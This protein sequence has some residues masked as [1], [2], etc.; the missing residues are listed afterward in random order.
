[1]HPRLGTPGSLG[2]REL[3]GRGLHGLGRLWR[4][5]DP[6]TGPCPL[7]PALRSGRT[8]RHP[9]L[10]DCVMHADCFPRGAGLVLAAQKEGHGLE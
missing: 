10:G 4:R 6:A 5:Q 8:N 9:D 2:R 7:S 1:M 3:S